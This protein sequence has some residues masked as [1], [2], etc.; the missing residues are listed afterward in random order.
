MTIYE[1]LTFFNQRTFWKQR[2]K[3]FCFHKVYL[4]ENSGKGVFRT[5]DGARENR[6]FWKNS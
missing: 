5:L 4:T 3:S 6:A 1:N 2:L